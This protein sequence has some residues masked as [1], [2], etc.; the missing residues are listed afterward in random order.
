MSSLSQNFQKHHCVSK[1]ELVCTLV[2]DDGLRTFGPSRSKDGKTGLLVHTTEDDI[3]AETTSLPVPRSLGPT[4]AS[5]Q[6]FATAREWLSHCLSQTDS[7]V[8]SLR[9]APSRLIQVGRP[10]Q[11]SSRK[12]RHF[13]LNITS[14]ARYKICCSI[15]LLGRCQSSLE[16]C[17]D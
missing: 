4:T 12:Y 9:L 15:L 5:S 3:A 8:R 13:A 17:S 6:S 14:T 7:D 11:P 10:G 2:D 16:D 1:H